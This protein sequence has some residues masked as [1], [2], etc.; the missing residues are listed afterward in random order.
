MTDLHCHILPAIDDGAVD[1]YAAI[2][3]LKQLEQQGIQQVAL[4]SHFDCNEINIPTFLTRRKNAFD[5]LMTT[6][7]P[8]LHTFKLRLGSEVRFTP[9]IRFLDYQKL[10]IEGTDVL[11]VELPVNQKPPFFAQFLCELQAKGV[12][13]LIAHVERYSYV[14]NNPTVLIDWVHNGAYIQV[15]AGSLLRNNAQKKLILKLIKWGLVHVIAS[16]AH[17]LDYRPPLINPAMAEIEEKL[18]LNVVQRIQ[19]NAN[20]LFEGNMPFTSDIH[21]PRRFLGYWI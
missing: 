4:T 16:D 18:G 9:S 13:P 17:S 12:I 11:L 20:E 2:S 21:Y 15:N 8:V 10:C 5:L 3:M 14:M 6:K 7:D 19:Q 1:E